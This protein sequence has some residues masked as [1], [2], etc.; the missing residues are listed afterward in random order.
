MTYTGDTKE[1][2]LKYEFCVFVS[3]L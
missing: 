1:K 3:L 2:S